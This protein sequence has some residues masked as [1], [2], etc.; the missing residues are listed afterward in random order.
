MIRFLYLLLLIVLGCSCKQQRSS[1]IK[2]ALLDKVVV[3]DNNMHKYLNSL[4]HVGTNAFNYPDY[5]GGVYINSQYELVFNIVGDT[6]QYK[7]DI[8][9]RMGCDFFYMKKCEYPYSY[10]LKVNDSINSFVRGNMNA[11]IIEDVGFY[12]S[13]ISLENNAVIV[14]LINKSQE[15]VELFETSICKSPAIIFIKANNPDAH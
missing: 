12:H 4:K 13:G 5:F 6:L 15:K 1:D 7:N 2:K 11:L 8:I 14:E 3:A 9:Q 10:L